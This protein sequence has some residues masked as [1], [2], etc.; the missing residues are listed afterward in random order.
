MRIG[1]M[2]VLVF[3]VRFRSNLEYMYVFLAG[4][5]DFKISLNPL[6]GSP[7]VTCGQVDEQTVA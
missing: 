5:S 3:F 4:L 1:Y 7:V 2:Q 6:Y